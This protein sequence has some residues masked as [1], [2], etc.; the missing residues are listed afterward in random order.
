MA[1]LFGIFG[2]VGTLV[3]GKVADRLSHRGFQ[4]GVW[5]IAIAQVVSAPLFV[6]AFL[7]G[8]VRAMIAFFIIPAFTG[9]FFLGPALALVQTLTAAPMRAVASAFTMLCINL[10]GLGLGPLL[11]GLLS[12]ALTQRYGDAGL[13]VSM[14]IF[15]LIGLWGA[16]HFWLCG[17][18]IAR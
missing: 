12:D 4:Y 7:A 2:A 1:G 13:N 15:S 14:A 6:F 3:A 16:F 10:I 8:D 18:A 11:V 5:L 9:N 17:R